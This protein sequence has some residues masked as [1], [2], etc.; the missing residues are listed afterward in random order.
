M[1]YDRNV[2]MLSS[3]PNLKGIYMLRESAQLIFLRILSRRCQIRLTPACMHVQT[4]DDDNQVNIVYI[5][6]GFYLKM[7]VMLT[8]IR[9]IQEL[10]RKKMAF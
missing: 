6:S 5:Q 3:C 8:E 1:K 4:L 7:F 2:G 9:L 10:L